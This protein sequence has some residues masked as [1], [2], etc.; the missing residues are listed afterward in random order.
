A[1][2]ADPALLV[3]DEP[4]AAMDAVAEGEA[5]AQVDRLRRERGLGV[6]VVSHHLELSSRLATHLLF[7]DR[8]DG[9]VLAGMVHDVVHAAVFQRRYGAVME[10]CRCP[11]PEV[12]S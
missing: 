2:A 12:T 9:A 5:F 4:T 3:L 1:L 11:A 6:L 7:V 10:A 8:D